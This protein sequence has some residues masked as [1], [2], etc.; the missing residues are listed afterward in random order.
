MQS[1]VGNPQVYEAGDQRNAKASETGSGTRYHE[2]P[3]NAHLQND[4]KDQR[5]LSNRA[6]AEVSDEQ[7]EESRETSL[8]K[9]DP[10][11]PAKVHGNEPSRGARIDA[12]LQ[13]EDEAALKKKGENMPGKKM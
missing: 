8:H 5:S 4:P 7:N 3:A 9:Q 2:G 13:A 6:A 11:L 10:T 1:N 12:E